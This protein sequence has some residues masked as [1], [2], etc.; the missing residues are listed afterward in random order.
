M[1]LVEV[2]M[3]GLPGAT[4]AQAL[5]VRT[6]ICNPCFARLHPSIPIPPLKCHMSLAMFWRVAW[7]ERLPSN[8][9]MG[10]ITH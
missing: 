5:L 1:H 4:T 8:M 3:L 10:H 9:L 2:G 7:E 6:V